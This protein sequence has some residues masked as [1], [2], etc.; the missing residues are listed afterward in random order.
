M[1]LLT[2]TIT[3]IFQIQVFFLPLLKNNLFNANTQIWSLLKMLIPT[4]HWSKF[5]FVLSWRLDEMCHEEKTV[6][7]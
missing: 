5:L 7:W 1:L 3:R 2:L 6:A 4:P